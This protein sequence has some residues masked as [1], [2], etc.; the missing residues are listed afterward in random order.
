MKKLFITGIGTDVGKT[1]VAAIVA[2]ALQADYW[3]PVQSGNLDHTDTDTVKEL[4]SNQRTTFHPEAYRLQLPASPHQAAAAENITLDPNQMLLPKTDNILVIEGAGGLL[5]PLNSAF[6]IIDLIAQLK[7]EVIL[8]SR[9]YLGS[10]NH[11]LL[12]IEYLRQRQIPVAGI[13]F[14][15]PPTPASED[16]IS[17]YS[18]LTKLPS[19]LPESEINAATIKRYA[20]LFRSV[21]L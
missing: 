18:G 15:G 9:N 2:E 11:T 5:V 10:I 19:V 12:S 21:L 4:I 7:A 20:A 14:N 1:I 16:F 13:V 6:L 3:K 17:T 8:V